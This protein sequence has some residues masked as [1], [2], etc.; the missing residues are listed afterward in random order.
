MIITYYT[1]I[2]GESGDHAEDDLV[3][4]AHESRQRWGYYKKKT[5]Q[6]DSFATAAI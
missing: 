4:G 6:K 2:A 5:E 3:P 1:C